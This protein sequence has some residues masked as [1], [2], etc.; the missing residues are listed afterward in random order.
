MNANDRRERGTST[1][2][3]KRIQR[4]GRKTAKEA[5]EKDKVEKEEEKPLGIPPSD[6]NGVLKS[7]PT[8]LARW[9]ISTKSQPGGRPKFS[10]MKK[11]TAMPPCPEEPNHSSVRMKVPPTSK[12]STF[13]RCR[14]T[15]SRFIHPKKRQFRLQIDVKKLS[16]DADIETGSANLDV[17]E[18]LPGLTLFMQ[19]TKSCRREEEKGTPRRT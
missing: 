16:E 9:P 14:L 19:Q 17:G 13:Q 10:R 6:N 4:G 1:P 15:R 2:V 7:N 5:E 18:A 11:K 12:N 8:F 3:K